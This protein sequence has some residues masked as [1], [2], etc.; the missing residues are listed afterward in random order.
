LSRQRTA[1]A[2]TRRQGGM[3]RESLGLSEALQDY[4]RRVSLRESG[5]LRRLRAE[6]AAM[7]GG[8]M[9][10]SPEQGQF[11]AMLVRLVGARRCLEIGTFT[12]YSALVVALALPPEGRLLCCDV[13]ESYASVAHRY[14]EEAGVAGKIEL[15]LGPALA[16]LETL[17][18]QNRAGT[19]D[20]AFIDADKENYDA[21]YERSLRL[22]RPGGII[23]IDNVL[24]GGAVADP[25]KRD[26]DTVALRALN[27]KL[28]DDDRIDL[29]MLPIGDGL[30]LALK[31]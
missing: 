29:A 4:L 7:P 28:H 12:G 10:I 3:S 2:T 23:A 13:S 16:T 24:W 15:R 22:I 8:G 9:Q 1:G 11:M 25:A 20:F 27:E 18:G 17:L 5:L 30:T 26:A 6:T 14:W 19:Y 21:Y 31:R